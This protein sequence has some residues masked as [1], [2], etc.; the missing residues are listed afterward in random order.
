MAEQHCHPFSGHPPVS[1][2]PPGAELLYLCSRPFPFY[3]CSPWASSLVYKAGPQAP[4]TYSLLPL[5]SYSQDVPLTWRPTDPVVQGIGLFPCCIPNSTGLNTEQCPR[6]PILPPVSCHLSKNDVILYNSIADVIP[7]ADEG[8]DTVLPNPSLLYLNHRWIIQR[9]CLATSLEPCCS[10]SLPAPHH[11][12]VTFFGHP[13]FFLPVSSSKR[14][15]SP[16]CSS[17]FQNLLC[18]KNIQT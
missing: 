10:C 8:D 15:G 4:F 13:L 9:S 18:Q 2:T 11:L 6:K 3:S 17:D 7:E 14:Q 5:A 16:C 12:T 1:M